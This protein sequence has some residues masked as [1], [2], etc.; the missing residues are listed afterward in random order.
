[1]RICALMFAVFCSSITA[2]AQTDTDSQTDQ[3]A[4][5]PQVAQNTQAPGGTPAQTTHPVATTYS[6]GYEVRFDSDKV[7]HRNIAVAPIGVGTAGYLL[8]LFKGK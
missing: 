2:L 1:M 7:T 8:M 3:A 5:R 4:Q 6:S